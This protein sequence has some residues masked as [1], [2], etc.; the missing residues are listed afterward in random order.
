MGEPHNGFH[1]LPGLDDNW[2][3]SGLV[4]A[5]HGGVDPDDI[6]IKNNIFHDNRTNAL[7]FYYVDEAPHTTANN[8]EHAGDPLFVDISGPP[9][10]SR[11]D[12][13]DFHLTEESPCVDAGAFLTTTVGDGSGT[14]IPVDDAGYFIDGFG[15]IDGDLIQLEE[16]TERARVTSIDYAANTLTV[17][18][19]LSWSDGLGV[20]LAYEGRAPDIGAFEY[21]ASED[22]GPMIDAGAPVDGGTDAGHTTADAGPSGAETEGGCG[23]VVPV[24]NTPPLGPSALALLLGCALIVGR[25]RAA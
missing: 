19:P 24:G 4:L 6:A 12:A 25:R 14:L 2:M 21:G 16:Q 20:T 15:I 13:F 23:C 9:D 22:P 3:G 8:W 5:S 17:D 11:H 18:G 10:P 7:L 1:S